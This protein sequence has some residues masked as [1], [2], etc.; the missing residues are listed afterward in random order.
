[1]KIV[2]YAFA[3]EDC[4]LICYRLQVDGDQVKTRRYLVRVNTDGSIHSFAA[5]KGE[6]GRTGWFGKYPVREHWSTLDNDG[7]MAAE[8][9]KE[10]ALYLQTMEA[11]VF[12]YLSPEPKK[13]A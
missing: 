1:M 5:W 7:P 11:G 9:R 8:L 3:L 6:H 2:T 4:R 10:T 12:R 13:V